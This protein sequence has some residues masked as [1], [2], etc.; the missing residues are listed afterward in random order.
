MPRGSKLAIIGATGARGRA[1]VQSA[2][3]KGAS[4]NILARPPSA[5]SLN[6]ERFQV[7]AGDLSRPDTVLAALHGCDAVIYTPPL[8]FNEDQAVIWLSIVMTAA[9]LA[10]V[11]R[12]VLCC[13][14]RPPDYRCGVAALDV[15]RALLLRIAGSSL[16]SVLVRPTLFLGNLLL[17]AICER[18]L[19]NEKQVVYPIRGDVPCQWITWEAAASVAI[20]AATT[21]IPIGPIIDIGGPETVCGHQLAEQMGLGLGFGLTYRQA[22]ADEIVT[23]LAPTLGEASAQEVVKLYEWLN[24]GGYQS[25]ITQE[26]VGHP[27]E[28]GEGSIARWAAAQQWQEPSH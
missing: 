26:T 19:G 11:R 2:L 14:V 23:A 13:S 12:F 1:I 7:V 8:G 20:E 4:V 5:L 24:S 21:R 3:G 9:E 6:H 18:I 10:G 16:E 15:K 25:L 27:H 22:R 17:P 28:V